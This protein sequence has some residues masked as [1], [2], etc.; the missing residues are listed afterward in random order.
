MATIQQRVLSI[1]ILLAATAPSQAKKLYPDDPIASEPKPLHVNDAAARKLDDI[2]DYFWNRFGPDTKINPVEHSPAGG[3]NTLG[4]VPDSSWYQNRHA[5]RRMT[6]EELVRGAGSRMPSTDGTWKVVSAKTDGVTPGFTIQDPSGVRYV[7]KFDPPK[8]HEMAS[9]ADVIGSK[10]FYALGYN[11]PDNMVVRFKPEQLTIDPKA[12]FKGA[13]GQKRPLR[14]SDVE[15]LLSGLPRDAEGRYR[16]LASR[17]IGGKVLGPFRYYGRRTDDPNDII[18]H[19]RRRE[20]RG[21]HIFAAWLNHDDSRAINT[22]D[23]LVEEDGVK[24]IKHY[25][26]DF[27]SILGSASFRE[28]SPRAGF[29]Y[30]FDPKPAALRF[31]TMGVWTPEWSRKAHYPELRSV[32]RFESELF[33]PDS[34][35]PEYPNAAFVNRD[36]LDEFWAAKQ[37]MAFSDEELRAIVR[38]A[39]YGDPRAEEWVTRMLIERRNKIGRKVF[40]KVLPIDRFAA[41]GGRLKF[42]DLAAKHGISGPAPY[43]IEWSLFD[44]R[45]EKHTPISGARGPQIPAEA[46]G[47]EYAAANIR[48]DGS[49]QTVTVYVRRGSEIAAIDRTWGGRCVR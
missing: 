37:V 46:L 9:A 8:H 38:A 13:G 35:K 20:L 45:S 26:I 30:T 49:G 28:N 17:F 33:D 15:G 40:R 48:A 19:Q 32:G 2:Y 10:I 27:G 6:I 34:W 1:F 29:E 39:E 11:V 41:E 4:E 31:L 42:E 36:P 16:A 22:L 14:Q 47:A 43:H 24:F 23:T 12:K 7:L 44:N 3:V 5:R 25:L 21:L 18:A